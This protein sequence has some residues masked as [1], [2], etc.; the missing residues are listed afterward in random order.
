MIE[1]K[2][3]SFTYNQTEAPSLSNVSLSIR[4]GECVLL[5][6]KSGCGKTTM[7]RLLN[8]MIPDFYDGTLDGQIRVK[9]FDPVNC[10]MYEI[11]KVVGTVFQNPRTQ[12]YTVNT[13][14]EIAFGCENHGWPPEQIRE[15]VMQAAADLHIEE[16]LDRNIFELSGGEKQKIAF[17]SI[18]ALNPDV[19][20]L[21]EPSSN[22]DCFAIR[23]LQGI[24]KLLKKQGKTIL[25]AEHRTWYLE[26]LVD[27]AIYM[28]QGK[29]VCGNWRTSPYRS[30][31]KQ[32]S[33]LSVWLTIQCHITVL[34]PHPIRFLYRI[35]SFPIGNMRRYISAALLSMR[36][37]SLPS[38]GRTVRENPPL[39][40]YCVGF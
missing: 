30:V 23:E 32:V 3:V 35:S 16:L 39:F 11:S 29:I 8:G 5:C 22:L 24:L 20:V 7:T 2:D 19:Y 10:S 34:Y 4:E 40:P 14:S 12:F 38:L 31:W 6:G 21:D 33:V 25:L 9:G 17:A 27:R 15:R 18:Y 37:G 36:D 13:T 28:E 26:H 1:I